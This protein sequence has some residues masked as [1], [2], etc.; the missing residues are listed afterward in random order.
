MLFHDI[1]SNGEAETGAIFFSRKKWIKHFFLLIR[2][3]TAALITNFYVKLIRSIITAYVH[4]AAAFCCLYRV[5]DEI[6]QNLLQLLSI[7]FN[8]AQAHIVIDHKFD[9]MQDCRMTGYAGNGF[10]QITCIN[11]LIP[12]KS[13][14]CKIEK[15]S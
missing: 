7:A 9:V 14:S 15:V 2:G 13:W 1:G 11:L 4:F 6:E 8:C 12:W 10:N 3:G 5:N